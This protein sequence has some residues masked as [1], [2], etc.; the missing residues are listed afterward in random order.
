[1]LTNPNFCGRIDL[2]VSLT[3]VL[4]DSW[5][6]QQPKSML[7]TSN[8]MSDVVTTAWTVKGTGR[9]YKHSIN[10]QYS[11]YGSQINC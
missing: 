6:V 3:V 11:W 5:M 10:Y 7:M 1:M 4:V 8:S 9:V 2:L